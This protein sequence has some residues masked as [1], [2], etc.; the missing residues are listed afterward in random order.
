MLFLFHCEPLWLE[1]KASHA[2]T[3]L[4]SLSFMMPEQPAGHAPVPFV[5]LQFAWGF[6]IASY[7]WRGLFSW[8]N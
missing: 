8:W 6:C 4:V 5:S 1:E 3:S 2:V 7:E